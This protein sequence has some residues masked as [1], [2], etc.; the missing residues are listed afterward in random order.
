MKT[1]W[2]TLGALGLALGLAAGEEGQVSAL[3]TEQDHLSAALVS[4]VD[5]RTQVVHQADQLSTQIDSLKLGMGDSEELQQALRS[6]LAL[7]Q[8]L[9]EIDHRLDSLTSVQE[10]VRD[11]LRLAYDWEIGQLIQQLAKDGPDR[12][13]LLRLMIYQEAREALGEQLDPGRM[14]YAEELSINPE[15]GPEEIGQKI[16]LMEDMAGRLR[17]EAART[18][19]ELGRLEEE[20]RLRNQVRIFT[21]QISL[22]DEHLPERQV[23][24]EGATALDLA[25]GAGIKASDQRPVASA[26]PGGGRHSASGSQRLALERFSTDDLRLEIYKLKAH[27]REISQ[28]ESVLQERIQ[29]FRLRMGE[30]L[31][32]R[33]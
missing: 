31:E 22:F 2:I 1:I 20:R 30:S 4:L 19:A 9:V 3:Q 24:Q 13:L 12:E 21:A 7:V 29:T 26:E 16:E 33:E 14:R 27:Q 23:E 17:A 25:P 10:E 32:G 11:Q 18:T 6:S 28:M 5:Q 15:D 8:N